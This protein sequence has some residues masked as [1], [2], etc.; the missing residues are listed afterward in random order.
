[1]GL[2]V[3]EKERK[4]TQYGG[5]VKPLF[6]HL[7]ERFEPVHVEGVHAAHLLQG[8]DTESRGRDRGRE[9]E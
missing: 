3:Q 9:R 7:V 5:R 2:L 6:T 1:M 8:S 4:V